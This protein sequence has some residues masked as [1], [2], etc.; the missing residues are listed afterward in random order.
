MPVQVFLGLRDERR[1]R[2]LVPRRRLTPGRDGEQRENG[3]DRDGTD[4]LDHLL[5]LYTWTSYGANQSFSVPSVAVTF[6][7]SSKSTAPS[8]AS[9]GSPVNSTWA[10]FCGSLLAARMYRSFPTSRAHSSMPSPFT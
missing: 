5:N 3:D 4:S 9:L 6:R 1:R 7:G 10:V 8:F 2:A